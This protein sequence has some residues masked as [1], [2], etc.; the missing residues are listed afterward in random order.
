[1]IGS[2]SEGGQEVTKSP[3][4]VC[5]DDFELLKVLGTGGDLLLLYS[6]RTLPRGGM[7]WKIHPPRPKRFPK[8][9]DFAPRGLR[10]WAISR[11]DLPTVWWVGI[12]SHAN[13]NKNHTHRNTYDLKNNVD[14][15]SIERESFP[16][17]EDPWSRSWTRLCHEGQYLSSIC[18][19]FVQYLS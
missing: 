9:R 13:V 18:P 17:E 6:I 10:P 14:I 16:R 8:G 19:V 11:A 5:M 4:G 1:M 15:C 7:H 12:V 2:S 3:N